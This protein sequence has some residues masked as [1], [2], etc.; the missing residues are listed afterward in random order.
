[1]TDTLTGAETSYSVSGVF[2]IGVRY[3][4]VQPF[5]GNIANFAAWNR[6]LSSDEIN[7]VMWKSYDGLT[8]SETNGLQAWYSLD[9]VASPAASLATMEQLAT[10]KEATIENKAAITA[11]INALS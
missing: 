2:N 10:D 5:E 9:D 3:N 8:P 11:A 6:A 1:M 7:S 4:L